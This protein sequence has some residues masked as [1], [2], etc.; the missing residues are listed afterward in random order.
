M[1]DVP[2]PLS[3]GAQEALDVLQQYTQ[4]ELA[5]LDAIHRELFQTYREELADYF[6]SHADQPPPA[7]DGTPQPKVWGFNAIRLNITPELAASFDE[8]SEAL[9]EADVDAMDDGL[10]DMLVEGYDRELW[11]LAMGGIDID[12]YREQVPEKQSR[13]TL[14]L[15][16]GVLGMSWMTRRERWRDDATQR[17]N[18]WTRASIVGGRTLDDTLE[19]YDR[20]TGQFTG[21]VKGLYGEELARAHGVGADVALTVAQRD[22]DIYSIWWAILDTLTCPFC[23]ALHGKVTTLQPITDSHPACR[24]RLI[25]LADSYVETNVAFADLF[26]DD[27]EF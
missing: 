10:D 1:P 20:L 17:V 22:H 25:P 18:Q 23:A 26:P 15:A 24:C 11:L 2:D 13:H 7:E 27:E 8:L 14:L 21:R 4:T 5:N 19:G 16:L 12:V 6:A 3:A 9:Y